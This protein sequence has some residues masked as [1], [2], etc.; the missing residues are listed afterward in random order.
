[1]NAFF[2]RVEPQAAATL[3]DV[4]RRMFDLRE[5]RKQMLADAGCEDAATMLAAVRDGLL[6][7]HPGYAGWLAV[8]LMEDRE[9][10]LHDILEWRCG[11]AN[12]G[13]GAPPPRSGLAAL[14]H[15]LRPSLPAAFAGEMKMHHDGI[16]FRNDAGVDVLVRI[17]RPDA[18]SFEWL[19]DGAAWRL[20]TAPW[21]YPGVRTMAH[22]HRPDGNVVD[23]PLG[24]DGGG[25][26]ASVVLTFLN[27]LVLSPTLGVELR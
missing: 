13:A 24:L 14:A 26:K 2:E 3:A 27:A 17:V 8:C 22:L 23:D 18:W 9:H 11:V 15:A 20:D 25:S 6:P 19:A 5:A 21:Q 7:E 10:A 16:S 4:S 12:G 1:M